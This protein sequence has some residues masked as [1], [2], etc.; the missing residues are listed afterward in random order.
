MLGAALPFLEGAKVAASLAPLSG[1]AAAAGNAGLTIGGALSAGGAVQGAAGAAGAG[2]KGAAGL[3][4][5]AGASKSFV[6]A[7]FGSPKGLAAFGQGISK[8]GQV[9]GLFI[10]GEKGR[11]VA[12]SAGMFG[13]VSG[14]TPDIAGLVG[15]F[16]DPNA[17][18]NLQ[19]LGIN[20]PSDY[21]NSN[22][23]SIFS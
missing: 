10:G 20:N 19:Q 21:L 17:G 11:K 15:A 4:G 9:A 16:K 2:F 12:Q 1:A 7:L 3:A 6:D 13:M 8:L 23:Q 14:L 22:T 18:T 5:K